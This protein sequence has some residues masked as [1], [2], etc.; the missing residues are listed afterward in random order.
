MTESKISKTSKWLIAIFGP[1][2]AVALFAAVSFWARAP[3]TYANKEELKAVEHQVLKNTFSFDHISE[4]L[5]TIQSTQQT[6]KTELNNTIKAVKKEL[7]ADIR[8]LKK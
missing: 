5:D 1:M 7:K 2:A 8:E 4:T 6:I 3:Y